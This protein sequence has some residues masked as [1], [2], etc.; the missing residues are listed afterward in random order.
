MKKNFKALIKQ[1]NT[2]VFDVDGV[3]TDGT[4]L[5][6]ENGELLRKM[7][8]KDGLAVKMALDKSYRV[9]IITGGTNQDVK[10]RFKDLGISDVY[11]GSHYKKDDLLE[12]F[13]TY[14]INSEEVLYMGDDLPDIEAMGMC[15]LSSC[16]QDAVSEVKAQADY[17]SHINGGAGCVR[18]VIRQ[19][20]AVRGD[21]PSNSESTKAN[22]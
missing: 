1:I 4:L 8:V 14:Q 22:G 9:C 16:P 10:N 11:L 7:N 5:L 2:F 20:M 6:S 3:F 12:Y 17:I 19:V 13:D 15:G 18:D 21:W